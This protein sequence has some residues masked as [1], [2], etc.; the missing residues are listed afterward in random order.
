[1]M[2]D[3]DTNPLNS[4]NA[5]MDAA[6]IMQHTVV[7]GIDLYRPPSSDPLQVPVRVSTAPRLMNNSALYRTQANACAAAPLSASGVPM[8]T[9][10]TMKPS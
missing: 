4:G 5:A 9:A 6:P 2:I 1:M 8:P 7:N 3:F 10:I